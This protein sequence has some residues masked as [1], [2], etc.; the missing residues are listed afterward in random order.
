LGVDADSID[1][2]IEARELDDWKSRTPI[3][4]LGRSL[5]TFSDRA[6]Y[7]VTDVEEALRQTGADFALVDTNTWGAQAAAEAS[8]LPWATFQ[9]YFT[10][11]SGDAVPPFGPGLRRR[12]DIVGRMRDAAARPLVMGWMSKLALPGLNAPR[13]RLGLPELASMDAFLTNPPAVLYLT[14][15]ELEYPRREWPANF[16]LVGPVEWGPDQAGPGWLNSI[17]RPLAL[18]TCSTERQDDGRILEAALDALP[19][20]GY[21]VVGTAGDSR[22]NSAHKSANAHVERFVAHDPVLRSAAVTVCHG[23]MGITQRSLAHGVPLVVI[24]FGRDQL[25]VA[26]RVEAADAGVRLMPKN[27]DAESLR[28]AV[29]ASRRLVDG[30]RRIGQAGQRAGGAVAAAAVLE[31]QLTA[32]Q[33]A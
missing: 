23:G 27:L 11:L 12:T 33:P 15:P 20:A 28:S 26:R 13:A 17:E 2:A 16:W 6:S 22:F 29:E 5:R 31:S 19:G 9:P 30:A 3:G 25:E 8:G 21:H 10:P 18:V 14:S 32:A 24:P 1:P 7:E 4:A